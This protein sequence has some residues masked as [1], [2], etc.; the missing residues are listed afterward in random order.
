MQDTALITENIVNSMNSIFSFSLSRTNNATEAEDLSQQIITELLSSANSLKDINA[1][2]GWMWSVAKN[3]YGKYSRKRAKERN[4]QSNYDIDFIDDDNNMTGGMNIFVSGRKSVEDE[5]IFK[6]D[7][8][9]LR[10]ELSLLTQKYREAVVKYYIEDKSCALIAEELSVTVETVKHL[11]FKARKILKEGMN[12]NREFGEKSYKP[13]I[14]RFNMWVSNAAGTPYGGFFKIFENKRLPG[15]IM[16][17]TYY[18]PMTVEE[19]SIELGVAAPYIEDELK[20]MLESGLIKLLSNARYQANIFIDTDSCDKEVT[21]KISNLYK[22]YSKKLKQHTDKMIPA[23]KETIFKDCDIS[24]NNLKWF[25][26][27]FILWHAGLKKE[28]DNTEMP[29]LPLGG[30]GYFWGHNYE[31]RKSG[32]NG[33]YGLCP[34]EHYSGWVHATNYKLLENCQVRIGHYQK[35]IDFLLAAA[36]KDFSKYSLDEIAQYLQWEFI[37][38]NDDSYKSLCPVMTQAQYDKLCE[39]CT[40]AINEMS[41]MLS[42]VVPAAAAVME[43]HAPAAVKEQCRAI[44]SIACN[45]MAEIMGNLCEDGYLNVPTQHNFL[46]IYTVI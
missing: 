31:Y 3:T 33:I 30:S 40:E 35:G 28:D 36:H 32:L 46:A 38:K 18:S 45:G 11:L 26:A 15:N 14:F 17:S 37:K 12:M 23:F 22:E 7:A 24:Q 29:S 13:D 10:R 20:F 39:L 5:I 41:N 1:F 25:T 9:L 43:N 8:N 34:S 44:A 27:H 21:A 42:E 4:M 6:E 2:Y 19:L 16:L